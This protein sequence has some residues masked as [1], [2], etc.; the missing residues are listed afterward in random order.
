MKDAKEELVLLVRFTRHLVDGGK[1]HFRGVSTV[2]F[3]HQIAFRPGQ[4]MV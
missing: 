4:R 3:V 2:E 1:E